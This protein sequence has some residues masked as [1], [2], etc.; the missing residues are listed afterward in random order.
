MNL[1]PFWAGHLVAGEL[2]KPTAGTKWISINPSRGTPL[3]EVVSNKQVTIDAISS[4][5]DFYKDI[6]PPKWQARIELILRLG[7]ALEEFKSEILAAYTVEVGKPK[8]EALLEVEA[9]LEYLNWVA[10]NGDFIREHLFGPARLGHLS[11]DF[12]AV[13]AGVAVGYLAFS[14]PLT[15]FIFYTVAALQ[16]NCPIIIYTSR[17]NLLLGSILTRAIGRIEAKPGQIQIIFAG[18]SDFKL[19]LSEKR[20]AAVLYTGSRDHCEEIRMESRVFPERRLILQSGGKNAVIVDG[21]CNLSQSLK[22]IAAGAF[23]SAGQLCSSTNRVLVQEDLLPTFVSGLKEVLAKLSIGPT[24]GEENPF[25]GPLYSIKSV[26]RFLKF[27]TMAAREAKE[28]LQW[29]KAV[30]G[31]NGGYFVRPGVHLLNDIDDTSSYQGTIL[32][33][34]DI[35]LYT[36]KSIAESIAKANCTNA[37]FSL[38]WHGAQDRITPFLSQ[39][40]APNVLI[41]LPTTELEACLPLAGKYSSGFHRFHGPSI[42][43]YLLHP[44]V[45]QS[46]EILNS[47]LA[48]IPEIDC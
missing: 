1:K 5:D 34:P 22:F 8:W 15:N 29:G 32:F 45:I 21:S 48:L 11:G 43:H 9:S 3:L 35:A 13:P 16:A 14:S 36:Y 23:R 28:T 26:E 12:A 24:D 40:Y 6:H 19:A 33:G 4:A 44:Q 27:Q 10:K 25:M 17:Q 18:F 7:K 39:I 20:V 46:G 47:K 38:S 31:K 41:N 30:E 2:Q 37:S 42:A